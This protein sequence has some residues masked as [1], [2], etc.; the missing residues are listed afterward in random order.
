[1]NCKH[2]KLH[3]LI[4][5][6]QTCLQYHLKYYLTCSCSFAH[7]NQQD[8]APCRISH[9][10][11]AYMYMTHLW[12]C[13]CHGDTGRIVHIVFPKVLL[14]TDSVPWTGRMVNCYSYIGLRSSSRSIQDCTGI[15]RS[16]HRSGSWHCSSNYCCTGDPR[17]QDDTCIFPSLGHICPFG[18]SKHS[19]NSVP[20]DCGC[21]YTCQSSH[22]TVHWGNNYI[23]LCSQVPKTGQGTLLKRQYS[24]QEI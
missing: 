12:G 15:G 3:F 24:S 19:R 22:R 2:Y 11:L 9:G 18:I 6:L 4:S 23:S 20:N 14:G 17:Y 13:T 1:M 10:T 5:S 7:R 8:M 21:K 16:L